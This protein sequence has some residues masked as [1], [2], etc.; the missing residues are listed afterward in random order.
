MAQ[1]YVT[2]AGD[3]LT[4]IAEQFYGDGSLWKKIYQAN[5]DVIGN[6]ADLI[7]AGWTLAIPDGGGAAEADTYVTKAGDTLSGIAERFYG[8]ASQW[9]RIYEANK[10]VIGP[11]PDKLGVDLTLNP[12]L[13]P[14]RVSHGCIRMRN[15]DILELGRLMPIG[16]PITIR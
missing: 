7:Q 15:E 1:T 12:E 13:L 6:N 10:T 8:D 2:Q 3:N 4:T 16:T 5:K 9:K 11:D 14:G